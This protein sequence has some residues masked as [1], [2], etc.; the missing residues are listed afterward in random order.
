M[1]LVAFVT[2][3]MLLVIA[4][5]FAWSLFDQ[6]CMVAVRSMLSVSGVLAKF[7]MWQIMGLKP[8]LTLDGG[9]SGVDQYLPGQ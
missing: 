6:C 8:G 9:G 2:S 4:L 5:A 1:L 3:G 7:R